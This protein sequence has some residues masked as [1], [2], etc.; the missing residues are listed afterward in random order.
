MAQMLCLT[1]I[2][3]LALKGN[4]TYGR[5]QEAAKSETGTAAR[6]RDGINW[7]SSHRIIISVVKGFI[8]ST[9]ISPGLAGPGRSTQAENAQAEIDSH[10]PCLLFYAALAAHTR[11]RN[12]YIVRF[13]FTCSC[14]RVHGLPYMA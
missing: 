7:L 6:I 5:E 11:P 1:F 2:S 13:G 9:N 8:R 12:L 10:A 14:Y 4:A 3:I